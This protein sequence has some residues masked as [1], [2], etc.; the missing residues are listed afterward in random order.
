M[1]Q[2][3]GGKSVGYRTQS[4]ELSRRVLLVEWPQVYRC[5]LLPHPLADLNVTECPSSHLL[6]PLLWGK[7]LEFEPRLSGERQDDMFL[8]ECHIHW[9][10]LG[11][12]VAATAGMTLD[13]TSLRTVRVV[14]RGGFVD[15]KLRTSDPGLSHF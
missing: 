8:G 4:F 5:W 3:V 11:C 7:D 13:L 2:L 6:D 10:A 9:A 1:S 12:Q 15:A 14:E